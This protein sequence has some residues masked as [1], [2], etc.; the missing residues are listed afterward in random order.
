MK[1]VVSMEFETIVEENRARIETYRTHG[2]VEVLLC[3]K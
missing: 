1:E 2:H 3:N